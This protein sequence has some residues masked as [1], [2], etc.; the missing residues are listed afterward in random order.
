ME[1]LASSVVDELPA[2]SMMSAADAPGTIA[3]AD[4]IRVGTT[5]CALGRFITSYSLGSRGFCGWVG[6]GRSKLKGKIVGVDEAGWYAGAPYGTLGEAHHRGRPAEV[7]FSVSKI[8][9]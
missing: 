1:A 2:W 3:A 4:M 8:R 9:Y 5:L 6:N 7:Y